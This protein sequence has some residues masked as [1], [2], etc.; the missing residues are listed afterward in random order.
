MNATDTYILGLHG[1]GPARATGR[2]SS[3]TDACV[4][5]GVNY[6]ATYGTAPYRALSRRNPAVLTPVTEATPTTTECGLINE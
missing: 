3:C 6:R 4:R 1:S 5:M 2:N